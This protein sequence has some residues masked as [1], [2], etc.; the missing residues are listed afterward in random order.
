LTCEGQ[1]KSGVYSIPSNISSQYVSGLLLALPLLSKDSII[2]IKG[3]LESYPYVDMTLEALRMFGVAVS[4]EEQQVFRIRGNQT[5]NS[6]KSVTVEGDWSSAAFWL[7]AG[8]IGNRPVTCTGLNLA[9]RQGD[10]AIVNLLERFGAKTSF[11]NGNVTVSPGTL[12]GIEIDV[13]DTP[14]LAPVL[15]AV[16]AAAE[17]TTIIKNAGRLRIKES[18]RLRTV[19]VSLSNLGADIKETED[20]LVIAGRKTLTGGE[21]ES[22]G[23]HRIAMTAAVVSAVCT[24]DVMIRNAEAV[25]KSYSGFFEDFISLGGVWEKY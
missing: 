14:D 21:T 22:F 18:D 19:T 3:I 11:E 6:P 9:S 8:A 20:G 24:G 15:A 23:D 2:H 25:R 7:S 5:F 1:L 12:K 16:A 13:K 17:G 4:E 10:R